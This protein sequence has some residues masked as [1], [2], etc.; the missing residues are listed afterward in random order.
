MNPMFLM[1]M[2][3]PGHG[4]HGHGGPGGKGRRGGRPNPP[5]PPWVPG[6]RG[7]P[8]GSWGF[9]FGG[10]RGRAGRGDVRAAVLLLLAEQ[11]RHGYEIITEL[12]ERSEGRW[13]PSPGSV[14]P[15]LKRLAEQG[16]VRAETVGE[17][18]VF[19]LT[20]AG[21]DYVETHA[22][23][24]GTPWADFAT[25][26]ETTLELLD[27]ARQAAGALWQVVQTGN[28]EQIGAATAQLVELKRSL[29]RVLAGE[30]LDEDTDDPFVQAAMAE[31]AGVDEADEPSA[32][33]EQVAD[34]DSDE[35]TDDPDRP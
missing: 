18:R 32:G 8:W 31:E 17:R 14:Y 22:D 28:D 20:D 7:A 13:Q 10:P 11:P 2:T 16:L 26:P 35:E 24:L 9:P 23:E 15:V 5:P 21:R 25:A 27:A 12:V 33:D 3:H 6:M 30:A 1:C 34:L 29:Y 19:E 4:G